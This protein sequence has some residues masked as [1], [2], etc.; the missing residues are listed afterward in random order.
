MILSTKTFTDLVRGQVAAV[1][2][3][4][5]GLADF[6]IGSILRA[7]VESISQVVLWLQGL[8][9]ALLSTTRASTSAGA[10]LDSWMADYGF[11]RFGAATANGS[12]TFASLSAASARLVPAGATVETADGSQQY[13]V[14]ADPTNGAWNGALNGFNLPDNTASVTVTVQALVAGSAGNAAIGAIN[15]ITSPIVG[16]DTVTNAAA[17]ASGS[18]PESDAAFR[19]RFVLYIASLARA[20]KAAV[21]YAIGTLDLGLSYQIVENLTYGG[22]P[23]GGY[24]YVI[25][26][27]GSGAT[28]S[29]TLNAVYLAI[30]AYRPIK[31]TFG[32]F[33]A[34]TVVATIS[35]TVTALAGY[36]HTAVAGAVQA[37]ITA[38]VDALPVGT[39]LQYFRLAQVAYDASPG[40]GDVLAVLLNSGTADL[41]CTTE[42]VIRTSSITVS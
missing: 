17:F 15:T 11:T 38:Y 13:V 22:S 31:S 30:D 24:F 4:A 34:S 39:A 41:A 3:A 32:V 40:V 36:T 21:A 2:G 33:A 37:A 6:T 42:Q 12:V 5:A 14:I 1:Q 26:D 23:D 28:P 16:V 19:A 10:D 29:G 9:L 18:D 7:V 27:D 8:I 35:L 20:T 25:V